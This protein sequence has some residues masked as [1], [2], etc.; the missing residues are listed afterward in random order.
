MEI[1]MEI[2][3]LIVLCV[4][5]RSDVGVSVVEL[6]VACTHDVFLSISFAF[7][8]FFLLSQAY[9]LVAFLLN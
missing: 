5:L 6:W 9:K 7:C 1:V 3:R 8:L 4:H 2:C